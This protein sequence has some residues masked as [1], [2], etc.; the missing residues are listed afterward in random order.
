MPALRGIEA[1][2]EGP[3][4][5]AVAARELGDAPMRAGV[6][7]AEVGVPGLRTELLAEVSGDPA[8]DASDRAV[9]AQCVP[10]ALRWRQPEPPGATRARIECHDRAL[11]SALFGRAGGRAHQPRMS[12]DAGH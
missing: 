11:V 10:E 8:A 9:P 3:A 5:P 1:A 7:D 2:G 12:T 4:D 6:G